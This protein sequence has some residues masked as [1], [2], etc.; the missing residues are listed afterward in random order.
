MLDLPDGF[1]QAPRARERHPQRVV[2]LRA[3]GGGFANADGAGAEM[4][5]TR[6]FRQ[7]PLGPR[8]GS[9]IVAGP[10]REAPQL[11]EEVRPLDR[12]AVVAEQIEAGGEAGA[13]A[14]AVTRFPV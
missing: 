8:D 12:I 1:R 13:R 10:E 14:L 7:G 6:R 3:H 5:L 11:L 9:R 4:L 2:G